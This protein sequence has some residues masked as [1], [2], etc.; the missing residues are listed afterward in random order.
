MP[1]SPLAPTTTEDEVA[2]AA[3][4]RGRSSGGAWIIVSATAFGIGLFGQSLGQFVITWTTGMV[5]LAIG[6]AVRARYWRSARRR[7][8]DAT[9]QRALWRS[10]EN[11]RFGSER[12]VAAIAV[13]V[14]LLT[15]QLWRR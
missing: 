5:L 12:L 1:R 11:D 3:V 9:V 13:V 2:D 14:L 10:A 15:I 8:G 4:R 7:L 6:L